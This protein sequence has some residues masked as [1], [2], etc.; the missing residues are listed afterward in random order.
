MYL[1]KVNLKNYKAIEEMELYLKPGINLLIGDNGAGKTSVLEGIAIALSGLFVN[2]TGANTKNF[3]KDDVRILMEPLGDA[4]TSVTYCEPVLAGCRLKTHDGNCFIW[5][6]IK[7]EVSSTHTKIDDKAVCA[8]MKKLTNNK[9]SVLP[10]ISFQSAAR[11]WKVRRGDF[12]TELQKK[13]DDRRCG[14]IGCLD[15]SMDVKS[16]QQWCMKLEVM[17]VNKGKIREYETFKNIIS[18][19]MREIN[20][21]DESSEVYYSPQFEEMAYK[22]GKEE[23]PISKLSAG[24]QSLLWMIMDLAYR[25]CLLNPEMSDSSQVKGI[26]LIDEID[27]HL[28]PKWQWN[29]IKGLSKTFENVQFIIATHSPIV[30]SSAREANLILLDEKQNIT[31]LPECYGYA[32]EDVLRYRQESESRPKHIKVLIDRINEFVENEDFDGAEKILAQLKDAMGENNSD[33]KKMTGIVED[34]KMIWES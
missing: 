25:V 19:F 3:V 1:E 14:Y 16:I 24:Y 31:Y 29:V 32:V 18:T 9:E 28:H 6:R 5:T 2:V 15:S 22:D 12:G 10:L 11:A 8:W 30:I 26:V 23:M 27:M 34:A 4:S 33:F 21:L 17:K 7:E 13:L 20:E